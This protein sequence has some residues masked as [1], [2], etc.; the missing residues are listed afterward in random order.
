MLEALVQLPLNFS[1][2]LENLP[3]EGK[4]SE[5]DIMITYIEGDGLVLLQIYIVVASL[6][7]SY[8]YYG[9]E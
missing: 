4:A 1:M 5:K 3:L 6:L 2:I 8:W 7:H 9:G